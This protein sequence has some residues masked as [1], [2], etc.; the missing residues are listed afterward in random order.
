LADLY[1]NATPYYNASVNL[2]EMGDYAG[3]NFS[4]YLYKA[5]VCARS[6]NTSYYCTSGDAEFYAADA[7]YSDN[8]NYDSNAGAGTFGLGRNSPIWEII[9]S[10]S[11]KLFDVYL[12]NFNGWN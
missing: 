2:A 4:G 9:G 10:P 3:Y 6:V 11:S 8:W 12:S 5:A 1:F 7:V